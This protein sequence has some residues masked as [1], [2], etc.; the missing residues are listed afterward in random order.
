MCDFGADPFGL[1]KLSYLSYSAHIHLPRDGAAH[2]ELGP[3]MLTRNQENIPRVFPQASMIKTLV[4]ASDN[5]GLC[6]VES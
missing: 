2:H 6:Q 5:S 4:I 3:P 1:V